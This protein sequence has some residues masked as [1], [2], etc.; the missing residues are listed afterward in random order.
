M[1]GMLDVYLFL[2]P[3]IFVSWSA[4]KLYGGIVDD[5]HMSLD[6]SQ[7]VFSSIDTTIDSDRSSTTDHC[8]AI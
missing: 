4:Y 7:A 8:H 5:I 1:I 3:L 2:F 6:G